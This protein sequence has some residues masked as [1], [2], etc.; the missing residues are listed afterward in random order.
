MI[1]P[2]TFGAEPT[3]AI[4]A[5]F[6]HLQPEELTNAEG[7]GVI[8][9]HHLGGEKEREKLGPGELR[10]ATCAALDKADWPTRWG[11]GGVCVEMEDA[12]SFGIAGFTW[13]TFDLASRVDES[14]DSASLDALDSRIVALEDAG[15]FPLGWHL[16]YLSGDAPFDE[17]A[18]A[19]AAVKFGPALEHSEQLQQTLRT[20]MSGRDSLPDVE[21]NIARSL[22]RTTAVELRF[23]VA[24]LKRR[25]IRTTVIAPSLGP[26]FQPGLAPSEAPEIAEFATILQASGGVRL[27]APGA[28]HIDGT[29]CAFFSMLR[30]IAQTNAPLFRE[31]L[32]AAREAF[33]TVRAGVN[34]LVS[35]EDIH[36]MPDVE[37][38]ALAPTFLDHPHGRQLLHCTWDAVCET[39]GDRVRAGV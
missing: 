1:P 15:I 34:V 28:P 20:V 9:L 25:G 24:E 14:A 7:R 36:L 26:E 12:A 11:L 2:T 29:D 22:R 13:F 37:D 30:H 18:L 23:L 31:I 6:G 33:P 17:E 21:F 4:G 32:I 5:P 35:E 38:A 16:P 39:L 27:A 10:D 3:I 19:R 8:V